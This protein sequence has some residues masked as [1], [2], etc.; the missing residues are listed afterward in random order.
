[1]QPYQTAQDDTRH[2]E[3]DEKADRTA[4]NNTHPDWADGVGGTVNPLVVGSSPTRGASISSGNTWENATGALGVKW[5][6]CSHP[7][8]SCFLFDIMAEEMPRDDV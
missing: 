6:L 5:F 3:R 7:V 2:H 1:M 8:A 4:L